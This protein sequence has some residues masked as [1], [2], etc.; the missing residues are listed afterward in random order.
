MNPLEN[1]TERLLQ[2]A[3]TGL[4]ARQRV[5]SNNI[6]NVDT[7][8]FKAARVTFEDQLR[9]YLQ[10]AD[11]L[12]LTPPTSGTALPGSGQLVP[13]VIPDEQTTRRLDGNNVDIEAELLALAETNVTYD[14]LTRLMANRFQTLRTI[15][16]EGR[17]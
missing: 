10:R 1:R 4:T 5:I 16:T 15:I 14:A 8:G 3:L 12:P 11:T 6:A 13:E 2:A 9:R 7:P 17:R